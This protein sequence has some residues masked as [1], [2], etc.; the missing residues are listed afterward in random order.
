MNYAIIK[1]GG[2]QYKVTEGSIIDV[3][4]LSAKD[5]EKITFSDVLFVSADGKTHV[6]K[7]MISDMKI[8]GIALKTHQ[9]PKVRVATFKAKAKYRRANGHRQLLTQVKIDAIGSSQKKSTEAP[10]SEEK[11]ESKTAAQKAKTKTT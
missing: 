10:K 7:P 2:K 8:T 4:H 1:T 3:E 5:N 9:G 6:G 11:P